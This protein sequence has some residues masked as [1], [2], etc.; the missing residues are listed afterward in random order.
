[1][2]EVEVTVEV[3][4][5]IHHHRVI[6]VV[7][8][9]QVHRVLLVTQAQGQPTVMQAQRDLMVIQ[10]PLVTQAQGQPTVMQAQ[11]ATLALQD[12]MAQRATLALLVQQQQLP[13]H[14]S[15]L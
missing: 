12:L 9:T 4:T 11:R 8:E 15:S 5:S 2:E 10:V 6:R 1:M 7:P 14:H 13:Q 3:E